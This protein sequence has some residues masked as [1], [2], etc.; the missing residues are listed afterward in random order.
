M[1]KAKGTYIQETDTK[2]NKKAVHQTEERNL[3]SQKSTKMKLKLTNHKV[4]MRTQTTTKLKIIL[5]NIHRAI[6]SLNIN[7]LI[8]MVVVYTFDPRTQELEAKRSQ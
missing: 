3:Q 2:Q 6:T 5:I 8:W 7:G 1:K 4:R